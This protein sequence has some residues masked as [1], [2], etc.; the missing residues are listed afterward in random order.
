MQAIALEEAETRIRE[1]VKNEFFK[2]APAATIGKKVDKII[3]EALKDVKIPALRDAALRSLRNFAQRQYNELKRSFGTNMTVLL[4]LLKLTDTGA[5]D[6]AKQASRRTL[7][8]RGY[9]DANLYGTALKKFSEDYMRKNVRPAL[10]RLAK[11]FTL[12]P[13]DVSRRNSLRNRAEM[14]VRYNGHLEQIDDL[15]AAGYKLVIAS[16]H[17]DCS[18]RCRP[19][20]G[21]VYSLDGTSGITDDGRSYQPLENATDVWYT[22]KAGKRYKNGLLGFNCFDDQTE[23]YTSDGWK[24]FSLLTGDELFY[25]LNTQSKIS[26]WHAATAYYRQHYRGDMVHLHNASADL[27][28][29]PNHSL[30]YY[31]QKDSRLRFKPACEFSTATFMYAGQEW[32]GTE[33]AT[34]TLGGKE[35]DIRLYCRFMAY[36]LADGSMHDSNSVKIAQQNN[37]NMFNELSA[38]PFG[39]WHDKNKIVIRG[40]ALRNELAMFG[41][42]TEKYV[43]DIIKTLP[44]RYICEFLD[45]F[46]KTDGYSAKCSKTRGRTCRPHRLL[47]TTSKRM[48]DDLSELALKGGYRPKIDIRRDAGRKI[49]F[50]NGTYTI[51]YDLYVIHLNYHVNIQHVKNDRVAYD[52][53]VYCVEVPNHTLLVRRNG[54]VQW[55]GNCRHYL[56]PYRSG[57]RFPKP[58][59]AEEARQYAITQK[60]RELERNVRFWRTKAITDKNVDRASY[61]NARKKAI[62]WNN[63]YIRYSQE[64][65]RAYYPSR[66]KII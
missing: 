22:T 43:P 58:N 38:L 13:D 28:V 6:A 24:P 59:P 35:V 56:I 64:H 44:R 49:K 8:N 20:Q 41:K 7:V 3:F 26:E 48:A 14:E 19:W 52:G 36:Y 40:K 61:L 45:A 39:V 32:P 42:C 21:R 12:D 27:C 23:V 65:R 16:T 55:C 4:A 60:Q 37:D 29:T 47:F 10:D 34:V 2:Q 62:E 5:S 51:N 9:D 66:T 15:R 18:E 11:Q 50:K 31:T 53:Y 30:L 25:T 63:E 54:R 46:L 17:A 33:R 1:T 57:Y